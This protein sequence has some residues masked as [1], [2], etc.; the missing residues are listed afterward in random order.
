MP[1]ARWSC[2]VRG[3]LACGC[4]RRLLARRITRWCRQE[5][6]SRSGSCAN[7]RGRA[8][9]RHDAVDGDGLPFLHLDLGQ[10]AR[11]GSRYFGVNL[12]SGDL[13]QRFIPVDRV[14]HLLDPSDDGAF[15]DRLPHLGHQD[16]CGHGYVSRLRLSALGLSALVSS[17]QTETER[18]SRAYICIAAPW[19]ACAASP[20]ASEKV[21][22]A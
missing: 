16:G 18:P 1:T 2:A 7:V 9:R 19:A 4:R 13:E 11:R 14:T 20:T 12:V 3:R 15:G 10:D 6:R 17:S 5:Q 21:G 8:N 22:C